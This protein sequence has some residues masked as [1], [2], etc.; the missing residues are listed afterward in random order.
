MGHD[1]KVTE[2]YIEAENLIEHEDVFWEGVI[3]EEPYYQNYSSPVDEVEGEK[4]RCVGE[5]DV[6]LYNTVEKVG[7]YL[8]VKPHKGEFTYADEQIERADDFFDDWDIYGQK[9]THR[10]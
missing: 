8:E 10:R 3:R 9:Y 5:F 1:R 4:G 7:L 6:L 2:L